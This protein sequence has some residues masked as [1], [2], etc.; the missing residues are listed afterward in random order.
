MLV[1]WGLWLYAL[2]SLSGW[3][4]LAVLGPLYITILLRFVSGVP[5]LEKQAKKKYGSL[6]EYQDYINSTNLL[7][8]WPPKLQSASAKK[9]TSSIPSV[10]ALSDEEFAGRWYELGRIPLLIARDWIMTSDVYEKQPDGTWKVRYEGRTEQDRNHIKVLHQK[11]KRPDPNKPGE[12]I[13]SF[14]PGIWMQYRVVFLSPDRTTMLVTSSK[15]KYLW[16][17]SRN[18]DLSEE[19]YNALVVKAAK[20]GFDI[21]AIQKVSQH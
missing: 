18:A 17:M 5:L 12:M 19:E 21:R 1:W 20:L 9:S 14:I 2:P 8:P 6:P 15:M 10:E 4:H 7:F 3:S 13:V 11:L 16:I